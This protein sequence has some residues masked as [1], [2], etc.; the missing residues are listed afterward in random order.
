M[1]PASLRPKTAADARL[2]AF[3]G[4]SGRQRESHPPSRPTRQ[5]L[6]PRFAL[7][8]WAARARGTE[9]AKSTRA[10]TQHSIQA[11]RRR[12]YAHATAREE[13]K[14][15]PNLG[16]PKPRN[17]ANRGWTRQD[18][19]RGIRHASA[20]CESLLQR[21]SSQE[22]YLAGR[23]SKKRCAARNGTVMLSART[24]RWPRPTCSV[25]LRPLC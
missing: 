9:A 12:R 2:S 21:A 7:G 23:T 14:W 1:R 5:E 20:D 17:P 24:Q 8:M 11:Q 4:P 22:W 19:S 25:P 18:T 6:Q 10:Q 16:F 15:R 13:Q 3:Q